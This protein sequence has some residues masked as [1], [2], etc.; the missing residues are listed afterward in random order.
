RHQ[1]AKW[2]ADVAA[3]MIDFCRKTND[4]D[5]LQ[6]WQ[7]SLRLTQHLGDGGMSEDEDGLKTIQIGTRTK[8]VR[9]KVTKD[10]DFRH[11]AIAAHYKRVDGTR[12]AEELIF[13]ATG[14]TKMERIRISDIRVRPPPRGLSASV[15]RPEY[16]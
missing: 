13:S 9:V 1:K 3:T 2:R 7:Y 4:E 11:P 8:K 6:F 5:G 12:E 16:L 15:Y 10:L 14:R